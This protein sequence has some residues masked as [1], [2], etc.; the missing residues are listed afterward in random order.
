M[1]GTYTFIIDGVAL[2]PD[3]WFQWRDRGLRLPHDIFF[4]IIKT[5]EA[6]WNLESSLIF[7]NISHQKMEP[8]GLSNSDLWNFSTVQLLDEADNRPGSRQNKCVLITDWENL[9][10]NLQ[11]LVLKLEK[12]FHYK[13]LAFL[14]T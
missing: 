11:Y 14:W 5:A 10:K 12:M 3:T 7:A 4:Q 13:T 2:V 6:I 9:Q 8:H 1:I